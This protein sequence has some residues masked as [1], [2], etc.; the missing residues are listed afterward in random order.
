VPYQHGGARA[1]I[2]AYAVLLLAATVLCSAAAVLVGA[3]PAWAGGTVVSTS[4]A[5]GAA[6]ADAPG[7]V[8]LTFSATPD[9]DASHLVVRTEAGTSVL[10]GSARRAGRALRQPVSITAS[11]NYTVVFHVEFTDGSDLVA[12]VRF[13]VGTG[14]APPALPAADRRA[15]EAA[16]SQHDHGVD[17][18][19]GILLLADVVVLLAVLILLS[20]RDRRWTARAALDAADAPDNP[21]PA[22]DDTLRGGAHGEAAQ[23]D[24]LGG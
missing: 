3:A 1:V 12:E 24:R 14:V 5:D 19:S 23:P 18:L 9:P 13:S 15:D 22:T 21:D 8:V 4:P 2:S 17:P 7:E 6:L 11:G 20:R 16:V 10:T